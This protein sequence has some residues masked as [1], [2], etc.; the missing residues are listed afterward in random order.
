MPLATTRLSVPPPL[1]LWLVSLAQGSESDDGAELLDAQER[2]RAARFAFERDRRRYI[3]AHVA[4]RRLLA[5]RTGRRPG[6]LEFEIG[7][8]G[9][10]RLAGMPRFAFSLSHSEDLALIALA[11]GVDPGVEIGVDLERV[12]PLH[13]LDALALQCLTAAERL[14]LAALPAPQR[15]LAFLQCWTR[16]EACLK[17]L[18][19][20]LQIEPSIVDVGAHAQ[21]SLA[22]IATPSG[23]RQVCVLSITPA[24]GWVGAVAQIAIH[25]DGGI[26]SVA[27]CL[28]SPA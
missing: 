16:K 11:D 14:Q 19:T 24:P 17:A 27:A 5:E 18:G 9:K 20:G 3:D 23:T 8:F 13:D 10:P 21:A 4:L 28:Y 12:R 15:P 2:A 6:A 22:R 7:A 26:S 1:E 25:P